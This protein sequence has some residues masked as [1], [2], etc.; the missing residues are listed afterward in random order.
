[1]SGK[2]ETR[3]SRFRLFRQ[4]AESESVTGGESVGG[5]QFRFKRVEPLGERRQGFNGFGVSGRLRELQAEF[6]GNRAVVPPDRTTQFRPVESGP[7][8]VVGAQL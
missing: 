3:F 4:H 5:G 6:R 7:G 1:M 2:A 8:E